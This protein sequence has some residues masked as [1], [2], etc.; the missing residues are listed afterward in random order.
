MLL[1]SLFPVTLLASLVT[2]CGPVD[3][4][5]VPEPEPTDS[6]SGPIS[7]GSPATPWMQQRAVSLGNCTGVIISKTHVLTAAHCKPS[8]GTTRVSFYNGSTLPMSWSTGVAHVSFRPG[9]NPWIDDLTDS[10]G[11][12]ADIAVLTLAS[13]IPSTSVPS[14][15]GIYYPGEDGTGLQVGRGRHDDYDN[16]N[17]VLRYAW[18]GLYS[19]NVDGGY[20]YTNDERTNPGD[21]GGPLFS[22][23]ELQGVL[24]GDWWVAFAMRNKYTSSVYYLSWILNMIGY[25]GDYSQTLQNTN[26]QGN[27]LGILFTQD[28]DICKLACEQNSQCVAYS[29]QPMATFSTCTLRDTVTGLAVQSGTTSGI[30]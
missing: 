2:G 12:F 16:P 3:D 26:L 27:V 29:Y 28:I 1:R 22:Q 10:N 9:V 6:V 30:R 24:W 11:D 4:E 23:G 20:F 13:P 8:A 5:P 18:N 21:S 19:D 25:T 7:D 17:S 15:L 14:K